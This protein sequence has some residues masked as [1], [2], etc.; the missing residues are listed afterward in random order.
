MKWPIFEQF[1]YFSKI[2]LYVP[3]SNDCL[4]KS[5]W[6]ITVDI[7]VEIFDNPIWLDIPLPLKSRCVFFSRVTNSL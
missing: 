6:N 2:I 1:C 4:E 5:S 7:Y 3:F